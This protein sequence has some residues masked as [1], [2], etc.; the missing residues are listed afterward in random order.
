[1]AFGDQSA[2]G[3]WRRYLHGYL[4]D[5]F[6]RYWGVRYGVAFLG[7]LIDRVAQA[8][9]DALLSSYLRREQGPAYDSL[10]LLGEELSMPRYAGETWLAYRS[11]LRTAWETWQAAGDEQT[12]VDQLALAGLPGAQ[13]RRLS[14]GT[15][16]EFEVFYPQGTHPVT[17]YNTIYGDGSLFGDGSIYGPN[18][19]TTE[20]IRTYRDLILHWKPARWKARQIVFEVTPGNEVVVTLQY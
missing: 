14:D 11:R 2:P 1:M 18:N 7:G 19:I 4:P 3:T 6:R 13:V 15:W 9:Q 5:M 12:I 17:G 10:P 8:S 16:S 20:Q